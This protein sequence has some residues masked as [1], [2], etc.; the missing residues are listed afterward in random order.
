MSIQ[1]SCESNLQYKSYVEQVNRI[2]EDFHIDS[3][4]AQIAAL[5][6]TLEQSGLINIAL[7]G[8]FK[9]G[10]SSFLN[11][12]IGRDV[13]PVS[14]LPL[15]SVITYVQYGT[16]NKATAKLLNGQ[17][18]N[19]SLHELADYITEERN[20]NNV[21]QVD[22]M[23]VEL[24]SLEE[25]KGI[26]FV[27]T[28]GFGS[29]YIH[30]T[31]TSAGWLPRAGAAFLTVSVTNPFSEA[32]MLLF[33]ELDNY[34]SEIIILLTKT[35]LVSRKEADEVAEFIREQIR[36]YLKREVCVLPFSNK[37]G[38]EPIR[39]TVYGFIR[40]TIAGDHAHK[41]S[42]IIN[43]KFRS[44][45]LKC[46]EYL[47]FALSA[48]HSAR[49]SRQRLSHLLSVERQRFPAV[50]KEIRLI[51]ADMKARAQADL[52]KRFQDKYQAVKNKL[53][54]ELEQEIPLWKGSFIKTSER[55]D[56]WAET[57]LIKHLEIV[58]AENGLMLFDNHLH[59]AIDSFSRITLAFQDRMAHDIE[60]AL[61]TKYSGTTFDIQIEKPKQP[62]VRIGNIFM[63]SWEIFNL[64]IP[65]WLFRPLIKRH[66]LRLINWEVEKNLYRLAAQWHDAISQ[67]IDQIARQTEVFIQDEM[68]TVENILNKAPDK[69]NKIEKAISEIDAITI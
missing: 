1:Q 39:Q 56:K 42:E 28:P 55:F 27:D 37:P 21:K 40:Q 48:S 43:H 62:D 63:F 20:P 2:C 4:K 12:L 34:T 46:R 47:L 3:M 24:T 33:K 18:Q 51:A 14:V 53:V 11:S 35:D 7:V 10:K 9:A 13:M 32:D 49:E 41:S 26:R 45:L 22:G 30:N 5:S 38:F 25:Y 68:S 54:I 50:K 44:I 64:I 17:I 52:S 29:A 60:E 19:V 6:E 16:E 23:D 8:S 57:N 61:H 31:L 69:L 66:F 36:K 59:S 67:S 15:T 58:S 65:M